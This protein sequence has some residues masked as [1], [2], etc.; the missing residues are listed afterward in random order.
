MSESYYYKRQ[1]P[2]PNEL[3]TARIKSIG[4]I[5]VICQLLEYNNLEALLSFGE[6]SRKNVRS[7]YNLVRVGQ[8]HVFQIININGNNVDLSKKFLDEGE[9]T[10]GKEK[11]KKGKNVYNICKYIAEQKNVNYYQ[12]YDSLVLPLE[13]TYD[14]PYDGFKALVAG[15]NIYENSGPDSGYVELLTSMLKQQMAIHPV[16]IIALVDVTCFTQGINAIKHALITGQ[17]SAPKE[18]DVKIHLHASPTFIIHMITSDE[19]NGLIVINKVIE[20][21]REEIINAGGEFKIKE[22]PS[23]LEQ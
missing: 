3:I 17:K 1:L 13:D 11:Y 14:Y 2:E 12:V 15:T 7:V 18:F 10:L 9:I 21:I 23:V 4:D 5:G 6:I 16:K 19:A 8:K 20:I 22:E